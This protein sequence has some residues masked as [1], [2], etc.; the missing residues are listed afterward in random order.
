MGISDGRLGCS[1]FGER[2]EEKNRNVSFL[3]NGF[4]EVCSKIVR[5]LEKVALPIMD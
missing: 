3:T 5:D 4:S 2:I 1:G